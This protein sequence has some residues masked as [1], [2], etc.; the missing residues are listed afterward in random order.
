MVSIGFFNGYA[1]LEYYV[2]H[3]I[4]SIFLIAHL[5]VCPLP[6]CITLVKRPLPLLIDREF[7]DKTYVTDLISR[8]DAKLAET[9]PKFAAIYCATVAYDSAP[10]AA[11]AHQKEKADDEY[12]ITQSNEEDAELMKKATY[13]EQVLFEDGELYKLGDYV[14]ARNEK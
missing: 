1:T 4:H 10:V 2:L 12:E 8:V 3:K 14:Y 11:L 13:Y 5:P 9:D 7:M 6:E